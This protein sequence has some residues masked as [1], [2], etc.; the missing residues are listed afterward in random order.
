VRALA[1]AMP[2]A[3]GSGDAFARAHPGI[4]VS[5]FAVP[6]V[7][8]SPDLIASE[9]YRKAEGD[10]IR[11]GFRATVAR[12][13]ADIV[14]VGNDTFAWHVPGLAKAAG[15]PCLLLIR[16]DSVLGI[17]NIFP[18]AA[19]AEL[20]GQFRK[21]DRI[22][23]VARHL[24]ES[25]RG[26]GFDDVKVIPNQVDQQKFSPQPK[27]QTLLHQLDLGDDHLTVLHLS[28]LKPQKRPLDI[29]MSAE[30]VIPRNPK[31]R[32]VV[33][34]DGRGRERM[35]EQCR[36]KGILDRFRFTGWVDHDSVPKY[37]NLADMVLL[38]SESEGLARACLEAQ[39]CGRL[40]IAS[41]I[42]GMREAVSDGETGILFRKG[43]IAA[44]AE[45]TLLAAENPGL[46][47]AIGKRARESAAANDLAGF[48]AAY[49]DVIC[50]VAGRTVA[51][52]VD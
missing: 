12:R 25:L 8:S 3:A 4:E 52:R 45:K 30:K 23:A 13:R 51:G 41:D 11:P 31:V 33:V 7:E 2:G 9:E 5:R 44:L 47:S 6:S 28:N 18:P 19:R 15:L 10:R 16:G 17:L 50:E 20:L 42:A 39:A 38:P 37:L 26:L 21:V 27:D 40:I 22:V 1:P 29:V 34:G 43:D 36:S 14:V 32:Y 46:R 24:G 49:E 48:V 35:E